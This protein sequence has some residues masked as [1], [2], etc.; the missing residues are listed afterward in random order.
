MG[1]LLTKEQFQEKLQELHPY[2]KF[3]VLEYSGMSKPAK[4]QC[5][6]CGEIIEKMPNNL[7]ACLNLCKERHFYSNREKCDFFAKQYELTILQWRPDKKA[8]L[9]LQ[10]NRCGE[11]F[12]RQQPHFIQNP[13][14]C[15]KC[16]NAADKQSLTEEEAQEKI[17]EVYKAKDYQLLKYENFH[18][19]C[20]M[21]HKCGFIWKPICSSFLKSHGC[22][23]C[24]K[25]K[26][27]GHILIAETLQKFKIFYIE[28]QGLLS[29]LSKYKFDFYLPDYRAAIEYQGEQHYREVSCWE[30][31]KNIQERDRKKRWY[32]IENGI[33]L[34]EICY[35][36]YEKIPGILSSKFNDY[37]PQSEVAD[38]KPNT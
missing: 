11:T 18:S 6:E 17:N 2:S 35:K 16:N 32:C 34:L 29:P 13:N 38:N 20:V 30:P 36:D 28:E 14:S 1:Q 33:D 12:L 24:Y 26:S 19:R 10:C 8:T 4:I 15:P 22:P 7:R 3:V 27:K 23:K 21:R 31:L 9:S 37:N 5:L 25:N